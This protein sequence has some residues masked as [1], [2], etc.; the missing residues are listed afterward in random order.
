M[1]LSVAPPRPARRGR[2]KKTLPDL[3]RPLLVI[4]YLRVSS[5]E[6]GRRK[7]VTDQLADIK[8]AIA[9]LYPLWTVVLVLEDDDMSASEGKK[10][11]PDWLRLRELVKTGKYDIV[12]VW[13]VSRL[14]RVSEDGQAFMRECR[15]HGIAGIFVAEGYG[16]LYLLQNPKDRSALRK[17]FDKAEDEADKIKGRVER[18][19][20]G[21]RAKGRQHGICPYGY[22]RE[23]DPQT[24]EFLRHVVVEAEAEIIREIIAYVAAGG[25]VAN[26]ARRLNKR[27]VPPP[28]RPGKR[29]NKHGW[30]P[31][32]VLGLCTNPVYISKI[33][34]DPAWWHT[35]PGN[36]KF[37][38][39]MGRNLSPAELVPAPQYPRIVDD[40][41]TFYRAAVNLQDKPRRSFNPHV[42]VE[43][44]AARHLLT[45]IAVCECGGNI[46]PGNRV[47][48]SAVQ[49]GDGARPGTNSAPGKKGF[50]RLPEGM[51]KVRKVTRY[52]RCGRLYDVN[53]P[54]LSAD[55]YVSALVVDKLAEMAAARWSAGKGSD[56]LYRARAELEGHTAKL[57]WLEE[58][59]TAELV[60]LAQGEGG[61]QTMVNSFRAAAVTVE[62]EIAQLGTE[63]ERLSLHPALRPFAG[64]G[65][66]PGAIA[67]VWHD[68]PLDGKRSVLRIL[69]ESITLRRASH[70]GRGQVPVSERIEVTWNPW[71]VVSEDQASAAESGTV[72]VVPEDLAGDRPVEVVGEDLVAQAGRR[73]V[74]Q[75]LAGIAALRQPDIW[76]RVAD[77]VRRPPVPPQL[78]EML[79]QVNHAA[80]LRRDNQACLCVSMDTP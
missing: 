43:R 44:G 78:I 21:S 8:A 56:E 79:T 58:Q 12:A 7:S 10:D 31:S 67:A 9:E 55:E 50:Q 72:V 29:T 60:K 25:S 6:T 22:I 35:E 64:C 40:D 37:S 1:T 74:A 11:R 4:I 49:P 3:N 47:Y 76:L 39:T 45:H 26:M 16:Q 32:T 27:D 80:T 61:S 70:A 48:Q 20:H 36:R 57:A 69:A 19:Q 5:D 54:E 14:T 15:E 41:E 51:Q 52:Y 66:D 30:A 46:T 73:P 33:T 34:R 17:E 13:E 68:L 24:R 42:A 63:V 65:D 53:V 18:G 62:A 2:G 75:C 28:T 77:G 59:T 38:A 23:Y 71:Y